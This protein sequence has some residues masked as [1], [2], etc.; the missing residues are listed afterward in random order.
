M[1]IAFERLFFSDDEFVLQH[2]LQ[3]G[4]KDVSGTGSGL[5][6]R[7]GGTFQKYSVE[8]IDGD[9]ASVLCSYDDKGNLTSASPSKSFH[10]ILTSP[11][12]LLGDTYK[13]FFSRDIINRSQPEYVESTV[14]EDVE[15]FL[16][17]HTSS[18]YVFDT[19]EERM[20]VGRVAKKTELT[21]LTGQLT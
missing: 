12:V 2:C 21:M 19:I 3:Y 4:I 1:K 14:V 15:L 8:L 20:V 10:F 7:Y 13:M 17:K 18:I 5:Y 16:N 6:G 9:F 11:I